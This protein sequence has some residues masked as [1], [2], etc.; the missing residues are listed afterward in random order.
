MRSIL[1][2]MAVLAFAAP[3]QAGSDP[4]SPSHAPRT[5]TAPKPDLD[6]AS[7]KPVASPSVYTYVDADPNAPTGRTDCIADRE[8]LPQRPTEKSPPGPPGNDA[9]PSVSAPN[10]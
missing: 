8:P 9:T 4:A 3:V 6:R 5:E 7:P 10:R 1:A 2:A